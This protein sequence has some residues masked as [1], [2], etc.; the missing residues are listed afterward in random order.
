MPQGNPEASDL[1]EGVVG[2]EKMLKAY[3]QSAELT[4]PGVGALHDPTA[5]IAPH[6]ASVVIAP[7]LIVFSG[8]VQSVRWPISSAAG[9]TD[10]NCNRYRRSPVTWQAPLGSG[11]TV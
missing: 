11:G 1:Q 2:G 4:E 9:A 3:K 10:R 6:F 8:M 7:P 5:F